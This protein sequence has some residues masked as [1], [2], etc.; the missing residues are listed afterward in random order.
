MKVSDLD[1]YILYNIRLDKKKHTVPILGDS[2]LMFVMFVDNELPMGCLVLYKDEHSLLD[3]GF[4]KTTN[5]RPVVYEK[6]EVLAEDLAYNPS[7]KFSVI[8][9]DISYTTFVTMDIE[10]LSPQSVRLRYIAINL[11]D[12]IYNRMYERRFNK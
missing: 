12:R 1:F 10:T 4:I 3:S 5:A 8:A 9:N 6:V 7:E 2:K 11:I